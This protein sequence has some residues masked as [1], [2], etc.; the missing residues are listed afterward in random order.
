MVKVPILVVLGKLFLFSPVNFVFMSYLNI[1]LLKGGFGLLLV[2]A[3]SVVVR[4]ITLLVLHL[5]VVFL[6]HV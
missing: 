1:V 4:R 6:A 2:L 5:L 3:V